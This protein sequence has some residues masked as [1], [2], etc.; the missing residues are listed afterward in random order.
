MRYLP[1]VTFL[2]SLGVFAQNSI[3]IDVHGIPESK[4]KVSVALYTNE[5]GFLHF[6]HVFKSDSIAAQKGITHLHIK[7]IPSG[8]YAVAVFYDENG[9]DKLDT[10]WLGIP[11]EKVGF[12]NARMKTF[13]P[14]KFKECA[15]TITEDVAIDISL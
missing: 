15:F 10:N 5:D 8:E 6:D 4:G 9:N 14:P 1:F 2:F 12:S 13:G 7:D 3:T 11:K